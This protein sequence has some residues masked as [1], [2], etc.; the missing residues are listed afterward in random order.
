MKIRFFLSFRY[1]YSEEKKTQ[2]RLID[3]RIEL[4]SRTKVTKMCVKSGRR[5]G[6][7]ERA[8]ETR[9]KQLS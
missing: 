6:E 4:R 7:R 3:E 8:T 5:S 9:D 2:T 1:K